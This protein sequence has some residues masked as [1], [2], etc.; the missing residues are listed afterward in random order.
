MLII[1][2]DDQST[3]LFPKISQTDITNGEDEREILQG[4]AALTLV[5]WLKS[6]NSFKLFKN[7][8]NIPCLD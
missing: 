6:Q 8:T 5:P 4:E 7:I 2:V 1:R 3:E